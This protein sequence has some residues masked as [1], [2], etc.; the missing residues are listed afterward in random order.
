VNPLFKYSS[1]NAITLGK[2][3]LL[4]KCVEKDHIFLLRVKG[5]NF[6]D[7][8][9]QGCSRAFVPLRCCILCC[10]IFLFKY[11]SQGVHNKVLVSN[12]PW[13]SQYMRS[14]CSQ[15]L[16]YIRCPMFHCF[17]LQDLLTCFLPMLLWFQ[18]PHDNDAPFICNTKPIT[19]SWLSMYRSP[20]KSTSKY[21]SSILAMAPMS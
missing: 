18:L 10:C 7:L 3:A 20:V 21:T 2:V 15:I 16:I 14:I 11:M 4:N 8:W 6:E 13:C 1:S 5:L 17:V 9:S 19:V 12:G